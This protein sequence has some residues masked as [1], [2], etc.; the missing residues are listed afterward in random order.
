MCGKAEAQGTM[1]AWGG[2]N[3]GMG[4]WGRAGA[5]HWERLSLSQKEPTRT[6]SGF[7]LPALTPVHP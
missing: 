7:L 4:P 1:G 3:G 6:G 2:L 5:R